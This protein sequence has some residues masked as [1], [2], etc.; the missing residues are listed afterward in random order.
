MGLGWN[1]KLQKHSKAAKRTGSGNGRPRFASWFCHLLTEWLW[2]GFWPF[3]ASL[4]SSGDEDSNSTDHMQLMW[5]YMSYYNVERPTCHCPFSYHG[6]PPT[7][8]FIP[9]AYTH[10]VCGGSLEKES[11]IQH[12]PVLTLFLFSHL[13]QNSWK[14]L[15]ICSLIHSSQTLIFV[16]PMKLFIKITRDLHF[17]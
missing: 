3:C 11:L 17:V 12:P 6:S 1:L 14:E 8:R 9:S 5:S 16:V 15:C 13:S 7:H 2:T 4:F 10:A